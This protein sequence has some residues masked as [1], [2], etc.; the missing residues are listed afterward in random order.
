LQSPRSH[1]ID[2]GFWS[3]GFGILNLCL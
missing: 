3:L 1:A 2:F